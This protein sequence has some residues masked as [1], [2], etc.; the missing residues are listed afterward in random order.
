MT[1]VGRGIHT[2]EHYGPYKGVVRFWHNISII[3]ILVICPRQPKVPGHQLP[4]HFAGGDIPEFDGPP[5]AVSGWRC[6]INAGFGGLA[7]RLNLG[8]DMT[9]GSNVAND[10][11]IFG[12]K[13]CWDLCWKRRRHS[14]ADE[15]RLG[16][17]WHRKGGSCRTLAKRCAEAV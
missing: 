15:K 17:S 3:I 13:E 2:G 4:H 11:L 5:M 1:D 10:L 9:G 8:C 7:S 6:K 14:T 12:P 16:A